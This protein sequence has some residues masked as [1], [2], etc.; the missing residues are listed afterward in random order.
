NM[1]PGESHIFNFLNRSGRTSLAHLTE[2][3]SMTSHAGGPKL[4]IIEHS[5]QMNASAA[6]ALL[7]TL[8]EPNPDSYL[9]L[10]TESISS[11]MATIRSRCQ[12]LQFEAPRFDESLEWLQGQLLDN[13]D[14]VKLL[15][16]AD[17]QPLK[18]LELA[19]SDAYEVQQSFIANVCDLLTG[20]SSIR[21]CV[22]QA[23]KL[24]EPVAVGYLLNLA[25][26]L[27]KSG[28]TGATVITAED[29]RVSRLIRALDQAEHS[30]KAQAEGLLRFYQ[31][32]LDGRQQLASSTNLNPQLIMES[33]LRQWA[34]LPLGLRT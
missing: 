3:L 21:Q 11:M 2:F 28:V 17:N 34:R 32:A 20:H 5:H 23:A 25:A 22:T 9:L 27:V 30:S 31:S 26:L 1:A 10:V 24:G 14:G 15:V 13:E 6:N 16:A 19:S 29:P 18:A 7:K 12:R 8:E 33:L 4:V